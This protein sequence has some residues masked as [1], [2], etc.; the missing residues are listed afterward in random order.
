MTDE[1]DFETYLSISSK[2]IGIYLLDKRELKNLYFKEQNFES[3]NAF[4][5]QVLKKSSCDGEFSLKNLL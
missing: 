1:L 3:E 2:K 4:L 5:E